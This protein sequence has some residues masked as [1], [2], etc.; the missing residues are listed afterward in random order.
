MHIPCRKLF[1]WEE[2]FTRKFPLNIFN[3]PQSPALHGQTITMGLAG[4]SKKRKI[5]HDPNNTTWTRSVG[6]GHRILSSQGW[7]PGTVLG[8]DPNNPHHTSA[9]QVGI[10]VMLKD[11]TLGL[12]CKGAPDDTCTGLGDL[13]N[14]LGRLNGKSE[15]VVRSEEDS[16]TKVLVEG[17]FGMRFVKGETLESTWV[18]D[19][20]KRGDGARDL[21]DVEMGEA[22]E[23][24]DD[25]KSADT[26]ES[27]DQ[28]IKEAKK[29]KKER[30]K[31]RKRKS[32]KRKI[33]SSEED[34]STEK[35]SSSLSSK[36]K[37]S[38]KAKRK[39]ERALRKAEKLA[40]KERKEAKR[41]RKEEKRRVKAE[42]K[43]LATIIA[44]SI[45]PLSTASTPPISV[46]PAKDTI[47]KSERK[48]KSLPNSLPTS[49]TSTP[50][51]GRQA[52]RSK[53]IAHKKMAVMD[54]KA[55]NEI[56]MIKA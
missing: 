19:G 33:S 20:L 53:W 30:K 47:S 31:E 38:D 41:L 24:N 37:T 36:E 22:N 9:S 29:S 6:F 34:E 43:I 12:G 21:S 14:L 39:A 11:D 23:E 55:L 54:A 15:E 3:H 4:P 51:T 27:S 10:K 17:R 46:N 42:K 32:E 13:Q 25:E 1:F 49:G 40:K 26:E 50:I 16:R 18:L 52:L 8:P 35:S 5:S 48:S 28:G 44:T 45:T 7:T 2:P 56:L